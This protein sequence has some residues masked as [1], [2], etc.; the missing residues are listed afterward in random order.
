MNKQQ[1]IILVTGATGRQGG[2]TAR[3]LLAHG[4]KVKAMTRKPEDAKAKALAAL[5]AEVVQGDFD[6]TESLERA[7]EGVWGVFANQDFVEVGMEHEIEQGKHLAELARKKGVTHYVYASVA[8]AEPSNYHNIELPH[9]KSKWQIEE[10]VRALGF[11]S[12]TI[13]RSVYFMEA[14]MTQYLFPGIFEGK[15]IV[16]V[17]PDTVFQMIATEDIGKFALYAF[18]HYQEMNG[19]ELEIAGDQRTVSEVAEILSQAIGK[20]IEYVQVPWEEIVEV[21][22]HTQQWWEQVGW[23]V[24]IPALEK[25][26]GIRL[27]KFDEWAANHASFWQQQLTVA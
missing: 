6:N 11:P 20:K 27:T 19:V 3:H 12:Y 9:F 24:D 26:Y 10:T 14:F 13:L 23:H 7:L 21:F 5:G 2:A 25:Q 18:E 8:S 16:G 15:L 1:Q 17:K 4:Y 22:A